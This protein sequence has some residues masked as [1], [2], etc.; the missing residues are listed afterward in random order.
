MS[1]PTTVFPEWR[2]L[3]PQR[4]KPWLLPRGSFSFFCHHSLSLHSLQSPLHAKYRGQEEGSWPW[5]STLVEF[6][7]MCF[8]SPSLISPLNIISNTAGTIAVF[9]VSLPSWY[10]NYP[11]AEALSNLYFS[12]EHLPQYLAHSCLIKACYIE[13]NCSPEP[14]DNL[15]KITKLRGKTGSGPRALT[16]S[17]SCTGDC[18][19]CLEETSSGGASSHHL[20]TFLYA[21]TTNGLSNF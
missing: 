10:E 20:R 14:L 5:I 8:A 3:Q 16:H 4:G 18:W 2:Q 11:T 19:F 9:P 13:L 1:G 7:L 21:G 17:F 6:R 12:P 15:C